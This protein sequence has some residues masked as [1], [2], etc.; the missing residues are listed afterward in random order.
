VSQT[1]TSESISE[2]THDAFL[3]EWVMNRATEEASSES[4][5]YQTKNSFVWGSN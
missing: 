4:A 2:Y 1:W 5:Q 3:K